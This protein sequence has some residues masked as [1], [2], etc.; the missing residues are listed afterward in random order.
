ML[1]AL[2]LCT[3]WRPLPAIKLGFLC[4][5]IGL[6]SIHRAIDLIGT[7]LASTAAQRG[8]VLGCVFAVGPLT[9]LDAAEV[10]TVLRD[11]ALSVAQRLLLR[12][13]R[14]AASRRCCSGGSS[15]RSCW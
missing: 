13:V 7:A 4:I 9:A 8:I 12:G 3:V 10:G 1:C 6:G 2:L 14:A 5:V 11:L 15:G